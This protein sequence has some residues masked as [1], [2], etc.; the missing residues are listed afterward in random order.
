MNP[1]DV[2][3]NITSDDRVLNEN[4]YLFSLKTN[5]AKT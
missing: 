1:Y 2:K 4:I 5:V 3:I